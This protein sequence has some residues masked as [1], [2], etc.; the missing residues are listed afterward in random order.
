M[1]KIIVLVSLLLSLPIQALDSIGLVG[2]P[3]FWG[4]SVQPAL[5]WSFGPTV[6]LYHLSKS[7]ILD[8]GNNKDFLKNNRI[9]AVP[10]FCFDI[11]RNWKEV[12]WKRYATDLNYGLR[13]SYAHGN[14]AVTNDY[15][16]PGKTASSFDI[17]QD[18]RDF[19]VTP[20]LA[21]EKTYRQ[22]FKYGVSAGFGIGVHVLNHFKAYEKATKAYIGQ[23]LKAA[24][25]SFLGE[26][27]AKMQFQLRNTY[28]VKA[29]YI[30]SIGNA[31]Y[32]KKVYIETPEA[33]ATQTFQDQA[34]LIDKDAIYLPKT[35]RL[36]MRS[37]RFTL[38][39]GKDF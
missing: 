11:G 16:E 12:S 31:N 30:F 20:Y 35:P 22:R 4:R 15:W 1:K 8:L 32:K 24:S 2:T 37:H 18:V 36:K 5:Y 27:G 14:K 33:T 10:G 9:K 26:F 19:R 34:L 7:T 23:R 38:S 13:I 6:S 17:K 3:F 28:S 25:L 21:C 29:E 39:L